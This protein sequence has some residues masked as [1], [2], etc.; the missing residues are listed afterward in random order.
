MANKIAG[1]RLVGMTC[2]AIRQHAGKMVAS[3]PWSLCLFILTLPFAFLAFKSVG[4]IQ[5]V[6]L[7]LALVN[8]L[9][10]ARMTFAWTGVIAEADPTVQQPV[11]TGNAEARHLALVMLF[12]VV[13]GAL[14]RASADIPLLL[15]F[16]MNGV[17][18]SKFFAI[19]FT[20]LGLLWIPTAYAG[21]LCLPSL[22]RAAS[23]GE[24]GFGAMRR[25][26]RF[27]RWPLAVALFAL[28]VFAGFTKTMVAEVARR[29]T[30]SGVAYGLVGSLICVAL[31]VIVTVMAA[32]AY[33]ESSRHNAGPGSDAAVVG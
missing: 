32:I 16:A 21:A 8:L 24:Y 26:M 23:V 11:R 4:T 13:A 29:M 25:A 15:Y 31:I 20:V 22:A 7:M 5:Y 27:R 14:L 17:G 3:A 12:V 28:I 18:D 9:A 19:L 1:S 10:L 30:W 2:T 6:F 33:R